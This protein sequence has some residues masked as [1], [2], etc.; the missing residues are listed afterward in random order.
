MAKAKKKLLP[1]DFEDLLKKGDL[2]ELKAVFDTCDINAR[3]GYA[4]QSALA[5]DDCPD[6][7]ARW[8][9]AQGADLTAT[10]TWG[11][12][13]LHARSRSRQGRIEALLQLGADV[14]SKDSSSDTPLH[15][16]A[17]SHNTRNSRLLIEHGA[18]V[19]SVNGRGQ[20]PLELALQ[21][22][23]NID[24]EQMVP[25]AEDFFAAGAKKTPRM[26][27]SVGEIGKRFEFHRNGFNPDSVDAV[28]NALDQLYA[29]FDVPPV[30]RRRDHDGNMPIVVTATEWHKQH[31]ELW[32]LLVPSKGYAA[33]V[34]GEVIRISGRIAH[35]LDD[36]GGINWDADFNT[37]AD[38]LL[39]HVH[40]GNPLSSSDLSEVAKL[41]AGVKRKSGDMGRLGK[42]AVTWVLSNPQP[43]KLAPPTY[44]R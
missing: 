31:E 23:N 41:V 16:A 39:K 5:F 9:I 12:T 24:L 1:K 27:D 42:L 13:P 15:A 28:S 26:R 30:P 36:N 2:A 33:T 4:K 20:T 25:L 8:L 21:S 32:D 18:Q 43:F 6:T 37:M 44:T 40:E 10:D 7:L 34:Q 38:A 35:E 3:G 19:D 22:C 14:D 29:L 11:N 17:S